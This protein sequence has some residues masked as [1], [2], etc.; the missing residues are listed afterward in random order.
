MLEVEKVEAAGLLV[1]A[2]AATSL[3]TPA[4]TAA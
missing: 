3:P 2:G 1:R 4:A